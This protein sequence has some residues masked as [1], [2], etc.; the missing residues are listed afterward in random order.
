MGQRGDLRAYPLLGFVGSTRENLAR[1]LE[2]EGCLADAAR[3]VQQDGA[4]QAI[5]FQC[6]QKRSERRF[7]ADKRPELWRW[8]IR[9]LV[10]F[11]A[12]DTHLANPS[13]ARSGK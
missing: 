3:A 10:G 8:H 2:S 7:M 12:L 5:A 1:D 13:P 11:A 6:A 9:N 4:G